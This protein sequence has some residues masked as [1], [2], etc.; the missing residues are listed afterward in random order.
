MKWF[1]VYVEDHIS[2]ERV[3]VLDLATRE[4]AHEISNFISQFNGCTVYVV[5]S[6][7]ALKR[8]ENKE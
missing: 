7:F 2:H 6:E 4:E 3:T 5:E 1:H 8:K